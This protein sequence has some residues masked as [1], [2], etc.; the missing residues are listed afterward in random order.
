MF[1][2]NSKFWLMFGAKIINLTLT[3]SLCF[4]PKNF[5]WL[6]IKSE[7][8]LVK[9]KIPRKLLEF[10]NLYG[11]CQPPRWEKF[12]LIVQALVVSLKFED[13]ESP[14]E[15]F[16]PQIFWQLIKEKV[17]REIQGWNVISDEENILTYQSLL[18]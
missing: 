7:L 3:N 6:K 13:L 17:E 11:K 4:F 8:R 14:W 1:K 5:F 10:E 18:N 15:S 12:L 16:N 2:Y 9:G